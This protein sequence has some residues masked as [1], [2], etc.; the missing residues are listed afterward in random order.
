M[1]RLRYTAWNSALVPVLSVLADPVLLLTIWW[2]AAASLW[3]ADSWFPL[4][5]GTAMLAY[6]MFLVIVVLRHGLAPFTRPDRWNLEGPAVVVNKPLARRHA[7]TLFAL[8]LLW[9]V[10][11]MAAAVIFVG[12]V[13]LAVFRDAHTLFARPTRRW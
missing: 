10:T 2:A 12:C 11:V 4:Y 13:A 6:L 9:P 8:A 7:F 3:G 5:L 1:R